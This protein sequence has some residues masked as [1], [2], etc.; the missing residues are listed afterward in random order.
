MLRRSAVSAL[1][2]LLSAPF[3]LCVYDIRLTRYNAF[4]LQRFCK[5]SATFLCLDYMFYRTAEPKWTTRRAISIWR[6]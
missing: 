4:T 3:V 5:K 6:W 1:L 2:A